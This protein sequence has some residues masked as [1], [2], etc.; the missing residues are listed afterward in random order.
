MKAK[1][2]K[3]LDFRR[4]C[5]FHGKNAKG[6]GV[7]QQHLKQSG[8]QLAT[9]SPSR[10]MWTLPTHGCG[11]LDVSEILRNLAEASDAYRQHLQPHVHAVGNYFG[12][13]QA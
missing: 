13:L 5:L 7:Y 6:S 11:P 12:A 9:V 4:G 8:S 2:I 10:G 3:R 1:K